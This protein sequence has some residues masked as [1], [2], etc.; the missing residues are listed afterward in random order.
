MSTVFGKIIRREIPADIVFEDDRVLVIKDIN[1]RARVH[2]LII[3]KKEIASL[4][5]VTPEDRE[6]MAHMMMLLPQLAMANGLDAGFRTQVNTGVGGGQEVF[7]LHIHL[8]G[9]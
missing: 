5:E 2:L 8:L 6:L 4:F 3:P 9:D 7:H 1:P